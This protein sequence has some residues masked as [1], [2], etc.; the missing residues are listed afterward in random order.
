VG[1][2]CPVPVYVT[3]PL[4]F[5]L[6]NN[7][8]SVASTWNSWGKLGSISTV[9]SIRLTGKEATTAQFATTDQAWISR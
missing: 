8:P 2:Q 7:Q 1:F 5:Q 6:A 4:V 9:S 3:T